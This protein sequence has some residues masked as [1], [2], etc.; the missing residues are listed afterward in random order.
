M[1]ANKTFT[2]LAVLSLALGIGA[3]TA[4]FSFMDSILL[5]SLPVPQPDSLV[6]M[7]WHA[8]GGFTSASSKGMS[9]STNGSYLDDD[10]TYIGTSFP[11]PAL[12]LF[13]D[14][15]E[16]LSSAF[17]YFGISRLNIT[18]HDETDSVKGQYVSG[19]Y[20]PGMGV[21]AVA[22]RFIEDQD[23]NPGSAPVAVLSQ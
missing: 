17:C 5:R 20:F 9:W 4:I 21:R 3:N 10:K 13:Q 18:A 23:D 15:G 2:I 14:S 12:K 11:Y 22:G 8:A 7:K 16:A 19:N 1:A 6:V